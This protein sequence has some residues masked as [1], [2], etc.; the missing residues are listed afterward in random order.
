MAGLFLALARISSA[1]SADEIVEKHLAAIG[2]R[3]ALG[4]IT[5]RTMSGKITLMI[6]GVG[7]A[8]GA[9]DIL[10]QTPNKVRTL[11][12]LD[13]SALGAG[14]LVYDERFDGSSGFAINSLQG[15]SE[16]TGNQ[17]HNLRNETFPT[18]LLDYKAAGI[19]LE[20]VGREK[21]GDRDAYV[22]TL[23]PKLGP[24]SRRYFDAK[25]YLE[26]R[27]IITTSAPDAGEFV[28]TIDSL[29]Y[30]EVDGLKIPFQIK[31]TSTVQNFV[32]TFEKVTHN[33]PVDAALFSRPVETK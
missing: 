17:L 12:T 21:V 8:S 22:L 25:S 28:I 20:L 30:R 19:S 31:A 2:G 7:D 15:N 27:Q 5:S 26:L 4:K 10:N 6:P 23:T 18:P 24:P 1:Q 29:D 13:L 14:Q 11:I 3:A 33:Q 16:L 9:A 32:V